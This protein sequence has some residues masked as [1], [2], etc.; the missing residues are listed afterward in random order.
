MVLSSLPGRDRGQCPRRRGSASTCNGFPPSVTWSRGSACVPG[1]TKAPARV[2]RPVSGTAH[3]G[4]ADI[5]VD[6]LGS[7]RSTIVCTPRRRPHP[8]PRQRTRAGRHTPDRA[9]KPGDLRP[10]HHH[11][12]TGTA[13]RRRPARRVSGA[14]D[15]GG[16]RAGERRWPDTARLCAAAR[17]QATRTGRPA[18]AAHV[19]TWRA[20]AAKH[21]H[22]PDGSLSATRGRG[23]QGVPPAAAR[24]PS[25]GAT[26]A[27]IGQH[28]EGEDRA[29]DPRC[30]RSRPSWPTEED[31]HVTERRTRIE[32]LLHESSLARTMPT[33][34]ILTCRCDTTLVGRGRSSD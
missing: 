34:R 19:A 6:G 20:D 18:I 28:P 12:R 13:R 10:R 4:S 2:A 33:D 11:P 25:W 32:A 1:W 30:H 23:A 14:A 31:D 16:A 22:P 7:R 9:Q 5:G 26:S 3:P 8:D 24:R 17:A 21:G 29:Y 15:A 27:M